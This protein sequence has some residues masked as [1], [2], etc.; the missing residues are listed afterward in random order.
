MRVPQN[1]FV[2]ENPIKMDDFGVPRFGKLPYMRAGYSSVWHQNGS[3]FAGPFC[4]TIA[5]Q[6]NLEK[7]KSFESNHANNFHKTRG[8]DTATT[9]HHPTLCVRIQLPKFIDP[10]PASCCYWF[11]FDSQATLFDFSW[12]ILRSIVLHE[13]SCVS[14]PPVNWHRMT[15]KSSN[16][17]SPVIF[18]ELDDEKFY[19]NSQKQTISNIHGVWRL[20]FM[21]NPIQLKETPSCLSSQGWRVGWVSSC[22]PRRQL[23]CHAPE[24][25]CHTPKNHLVDIPIILG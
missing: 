6:Q 20:M 12:W 15:G 21:Q 1:L 9:V 17:S 8:L 7:Y 16:W 19:R 5:W 14:L 3:R 25:R 22:L 11:P 4:V 2:I 13:F 10:S 18:L 24:M 23:P